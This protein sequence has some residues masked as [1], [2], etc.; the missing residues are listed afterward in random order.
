MYLTFKKN[1][2]FQLPSDGI[3]HFINQEV[4]QQ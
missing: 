2:N 3:D 1:N 4:L